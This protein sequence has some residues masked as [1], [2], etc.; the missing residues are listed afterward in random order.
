MARIPQEPKKE[1]IDYLKSLVAIGFSK[2]VTTAYDCSSLATAIETTIQK[3]VSVDTLRRFFGV[4]NSTS[5]PSTYTLDVLSKYVGYK[6]WS[7]LIAGYQEEKQ[8]HQ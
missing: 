7:D 1:H 2:N 8:L 6:N 4:I 3:K 5:L